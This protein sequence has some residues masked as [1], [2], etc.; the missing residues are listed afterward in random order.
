MSSIGYGTTISMDPRHMIGSVDDGTAPRRAAAAAPDPLA[1]VADQL[2]PLLF[3]RLKAMLRGVHSEAEMI[4]E[5]ARDTPGLDALSAAAL[6]DWLEERGLGVEA[7]RVRRLPVQDGDLLVITVPDS[8]SPEGRANSL[9]PPCPSGRTNCRAPSALKRIWV[10]GV[11]CASLCSKLL[12]VQAHQVPRLPR[13]SAPRPAPR[14]GHSKSS[15]RKS[16]WH[17]ALES[18]P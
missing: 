2:A 3:D 9:S 13:G 5:A 14:R 15:G 11:M 18:R 16:R 17:P 12:L 6:G 1:A 7:E 8:L 4:A 10:E